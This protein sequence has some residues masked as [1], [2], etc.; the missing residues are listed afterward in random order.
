[1][2]TALNSVLASVLLLAPRPTRK[3]YGASRKRPK[4]LPPKQFGGACGPAL[5]HI[6]VAVAAEDEPVAL[7]LDVDD[8]E[9]FLSPS[10]RRSIRAVSVC[11]PSSPAGGGSPPEESV[12]FRALDAQDHPGRDVDVRIFAVSVWG[13]T[14]DL[15]DP[16]G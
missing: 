1:L 4:P 6:A 7:P 5:D 2:T 15:R 9:A 10:L 11:T 12:A 8:R 14:R 3:W 16:G 13:E